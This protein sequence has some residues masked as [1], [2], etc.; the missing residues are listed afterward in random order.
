MIKLHFV[1]LNSLN[2]TI[3]KPN[4][5]YIWVLIWGLMMWSWYRAFWHSFQRLPFPWYSLCP[6]DHRV[7][8]IELFILLLL[9]SSSGT[10]R[11]IS[12]LSDHWS[13]VW[14]T[15]SNDLMK[16]PGISRIHLFLRPC[17]P[18]THLCEA[19]W[20]VRDVGIDSTI[21][22]GRANRMLSAKSG[23]NIYQDIF[24]W[25]HIVRFSIILSSYSR[26]V[27]FRRVLILL[28]A[29]LVFVL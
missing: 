20:A 26:N 4:N 8:G 13:L 15:A 25:A 27:C 2:L 10:R 24:L 9:S 5:N 16:A 29:I 18:R 12:H 1:P 19:L 7:D 14:T 17:I 21:D 6:N 23:L 28:S 3:L 11:R 22:V